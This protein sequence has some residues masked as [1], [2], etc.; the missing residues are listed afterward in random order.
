MNLGTM[1][2]DKC[3]L[4]TYFVLG[5]AFEGWD[6]LGLLDIYEVDTWGTPLGV[7]GILELLAPLRL[8]IFLTFSSKC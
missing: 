6:R 7:A 2:L 4:L 5:V 1:I 3:I 8:L